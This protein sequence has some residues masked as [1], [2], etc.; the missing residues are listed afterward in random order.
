M[1]NQLESVLQ[2]LNKRLQMALES[3]ATNQVESLQ[4]EKQAY[5]K[6]LMRL[7]LRTILQGRVQQIVWDSQDQ[8]NQ[9]KHQFETWFQDMNHIENRL[10]LS[11]DSQTGEAIGRQLIHERN[12]VLRD[13]GDEY[14]DLV[15]SVRIK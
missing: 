13:Y 12:Q 14:R 10:K 6:K 4:T 15:K 3:G 2:D 11:F 7:K 9:E 1:S 5:E 8:L